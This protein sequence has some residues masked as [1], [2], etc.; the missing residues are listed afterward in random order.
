MNIFHN[1][2]GTIQVDHVE[3]TGF[4]SMI[5]EHMHQG[6][7][8][9]YLFSGE[10]DYFIRDRTFRVK[11]GSFVF[12]EKE[13]LHRTIDAGAPKHERVVINFAAPLLE[14]SGLNGRSGVV[15]LAPQDQYKGEALVR[16]LIAEAKGD[17]PGRDMMLESLLKQL[18]VHVFRAQTEQLEPEAQP[19]ALHRTMSEVAEY[20]GSHYREEL[21]LKDVAERFFV[22]P[23]YLSRKFK[24]CTGFGFAEYVQLV[25]IREAQRLLRETNLKMIEVAERTG[26]GTIA[27]FH[28]LF[29]KMNG[30]SP[31]QY[32]KLQR[33]LPASAKESSI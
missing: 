22:S 30:C 28:K 12:I 7:E 27:N 31:L 19:S 6:Y 29:R 8:L 26:I 15:T 24:Q 18:L 2:A 5:N 11:R 20:V 33:T 23:Y 25:R 13:E 32:R 10:R 9:Y 4:Y 14:G 3:R 21:H 17:A 1:S 16:E